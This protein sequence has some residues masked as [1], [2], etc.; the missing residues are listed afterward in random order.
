MTELKETKTLIE[1][2]CAGDDSVVAELFERYRERLKRLVTLRMH[3]Q[4]R[5]RLD[6][7][8][9]LQEA[10]IELAR[11]LPKYA[12]E[13]EIPFFVWL[14][15]IATD[16]LKQLQ[17]KHLRAEKRTAY[18]EVDLA[19]MPLN[20]ASILNLASQLAGQFTS[21]D[22]NLIKE[23]VQRKLMDAL[24]RME[25][26]DREIV[27]MRHFEE[28][29]TQEIAELV[30]LTRSGVLKRYTRAIERLQESV[31]GDTEFQAE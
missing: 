25:V 19:S 16:S 3:P 30:G 26:N 9:V 1:Q 18:R 10:Y 23:E 17:R 11:R 14:R 24:D 29:S 28:L 8:D 12:E 22:R 15:M 5:S 27:A 21:V 31:L 2:A 4:M 13:R 6:A 7:S 20:D